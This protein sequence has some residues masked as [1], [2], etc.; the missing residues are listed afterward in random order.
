MSFI[1]R[2]VELKDLQG[3][4]VIFEGIYEKKKS[5]SLDEP[6]GEYENLIAV[7]I[8]GEVV[9]MKGLGHFYHPDTGEAYTL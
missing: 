5:T 3:N 7:M 8:D 1:K 6:S 9:R 4:K 2:E